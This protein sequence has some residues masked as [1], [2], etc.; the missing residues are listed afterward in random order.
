MAKLALHPVCKWF[1]EM[2]QEDLQ[3]LADDI[4]EN[5]QQLPILV[6][7]GKIC[8]GRNRELACEIAG[9]KPQT[10]TMKR[11]PTPAEIVALNLHRRHLTLGQRLEVASNLREHYVKFGQQR[12]QENLKN[13]RKS[14]E[15]TT[16][17]PSDNDG[18]NAPGKALERAAAE[19]GVSHTTLQK[20]DAVKDKSPEL[21]E[22][23]RED[24][25]TV[26][27]AARQVMEDNTETKSPKPTIAKDAMGIPLA[28][29][30]VPVFN[31]LELFK[32][33]DSLCRK[34]QDVIEKLSSNPAGA[35]FR[36]ELET[37]SKGEGP[38]RHRHK[39]LQQIKSDLKLSR[40][41][42]RCPYCASRENGKA[43]KDCKTCKGCGWA[44]KMTFDSSPA[45]YRA[46][47]EKTK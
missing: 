39:S 46:A 44:T 5:G 36:R 27:A 6:W 25:I 3:K 16:V 18:D 31:G 15:G 32:E 37:S 7:G 10:K 33:A 20:Y 9:V 35:A 28:A 26:A 21:A 24:E 17:V 47:V 11:E 8:D 22:A 1:P 13:G 40:P 29:Y 38:M 43:F 12:K 23:I 30:L 19:A 14:P 45:D 2:E 4:K 34:L 42:T 41:Y